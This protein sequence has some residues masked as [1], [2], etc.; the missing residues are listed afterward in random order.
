MRISTLS[1]YEQGT[2]TID[3]AQ[4]NM[5]QT[6]EQIATGYKVNVP[7][8]NPLAATQILAV[9]S[10][11][12][13]NT[14]YAT[15]LNTAQASLGLADNTLTEITSTLQSIRTT[16][17]QAGNGSLSSADKTSIATQ[18]QSQLNTLVS[19][20]NTQDGQGQYLFSG[21][22]QNTP[23]FQQNGS[24]VSYVGN[25]A[26][27]NVQVTASTQIQSTVTGDEIFQRVKSGNGVFTTG[28]A[29][30]NTGTGVIDTGSVTN[31]GALTGDPYSIQ[32]AV[33]GGNTTYTV[34]D[35]K[36]GAVVAAPAAGANTYTAGQAISF[37]GL[38]VTVQGSPA[39]GDTF[40]V[41]PSTNQSIFSSVQQAISA[42]TTSANSGSAGPLGGIS[43]MIQNVDQAISQVSTVQASVGASENQVSTLL[44]VNTTTGTNQAS[45]LA[46]LQDTDMAQAASNLVEE[47]TVLQA[48]EQSFSKISG[49][50]LFNYIQG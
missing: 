44:S 48:A 4:S 30:T 40:S 21:S 1:F 50:S 31:P 47:Q 12:S 34:T 49:D 39:N 15:N 35:N 33:A 10:A 42:L 11:Q 18:L 22:I 38:E 7:G 29:S 41:A 6:Q 25:Q 23:P 13:S 14:Q 37:D 17:V 8:D 3:N 16:L 19:L 9:T 27:R 24:S 20:A 36:T 5:A 28:A 46:N 2:T 26:V 45:Q 43:G 32:F